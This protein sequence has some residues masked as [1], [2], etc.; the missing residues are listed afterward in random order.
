VNGTILQARHFV[1]A[2]GSRA[3]IPDLPGLDEARVFTNETIFDRLES[4]PRS[5]LVLGG[6]PVGCELAQVFVRLG[7]QVILAQR[8]GRL[9]PREDPD[10]SEF[11]LARLQSE[12]ARVILNARIDRLETVGGETRVFFAPGQTDAAGQG[13][14]P[15][16]IET[17]L[18]AAGR[19]PNVENLNLGA[20][21]VV[22]DPEGVRVNRYL[23]TSQPRV[24]AAG[25]VAG[26]YHFTHVADAQA[27]VVVRNTLMPWQALWQKMDYSAIPWCTY[28]APEVA[29]VGLNETEATR[30]GIA[31]DLYRL[32]MSEVDRAVLESEETGFAKALTQKG[33]DRILGATLVCEHAGDLLPEFVLAM[34]HRIGLGA[35]AS[36]IHAYPTQSELVRKLGDRYNR[37]RLTPRAKKLFAWL[38][39]RQTR[40]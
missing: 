25:D 9:L 3:A 35:L 2:T 14:S 18:V 15:A 23:Q 13:C 11:V 7:V 6:G 27:R 17:V 19:K 40:A 29:R 1:I 21:G 31:Y 10:A 8:A 4:R 20:A 24:F 26:P 33:G 30:L 5:L 38:Y 28:T 16:T 37:T 34:K 36:V 12:G 22:C 32:P 39:A